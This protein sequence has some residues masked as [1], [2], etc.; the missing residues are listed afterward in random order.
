MKGNRV[1]VTGGAGFIGSHLVD[2][3]ASRMLNISVL[4]NLSSGSLTNI[5]QWLRDTNLSFKH[6][7]LLNIEDVAKAVEGCDTIIHLAANPEVKISTANPEVHYRQNI[8]ATFNL[9][10]AVRRIGSAEVFLFTSSST[11]YGEA[12][13]IPTPEDYTPM[14]PISVYGS[15][16]LSCE[17]LITGYAHAY[18]FRAIIYRLANIVGSRNTHGVV[19]DF[20]QKLRRNPGELEVLG[21]GTQTKSYLFINDCI[22]AIETGLKRAKSRVEIFNIGSDDQIDVKSLANIVIGEMGLKNVKVTF[23][24]GVNGGR[25]WPGDV[26]NMLLETSKLKLEGWRPRYNSEESVRLAVKDILSKN[27]EPC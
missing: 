11:V 21:N 7:D 1:L 18:G 13:K 24:G 12:S 14:K 27:R 20:V 22:R 17:A 8:Q 25:G 5:S 6:A 2:E 4:D 10:E 19:N 15:S 16:K 23:T 9:L 26:K 3:L